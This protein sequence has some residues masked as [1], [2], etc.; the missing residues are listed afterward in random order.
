MCV[1]IWCAVCVRAFIV[2]MRVCVVCDL[3]FDVVCLVGVCLLWFFVSILCSCVSCVSD[4]G[5]GWGVVI[6]VFVCVCCVC[7]FCLGALFVIVLG[8]VV[9][10]ACLYD[11][12]CVCVI[13]V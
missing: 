13:V 12:L 7:V 5:V 4:C 6:F 8:G 3:L 10:S 2:V 11:C 1:C 9:W